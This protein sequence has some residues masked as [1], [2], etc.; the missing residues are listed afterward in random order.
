V[1]S[2]PEHLRAYLEIAAIWNESKALETPGPLCFDDELANVVELASVTCGSAATATQASGSHRRPFASVAAAAL[3]AVIFGLGAIIWYQL[4]RAP[5]YATEFGEQRSLRLADGSTVELNSRSQIRVRFTERERM[6]E[7]LY[8][9]ALFQVSKDVAR[10][11]VVSSR[12][13]RVRAVG[14]RF[15]VNLRSSGAIVTVLEGRVAVTD[16]ASN[17]SAA[18]GAGEQVILRPRTAPRPVNANVSAVTAWTQRQL[19]FESERLSDVAETF[20]RYSA[21]PLVVEDQGRAELRLSGVFST[22]PDFLIRYLKQRPDITVRET[23][24]EIHITRH[25]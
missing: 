13:A 21:R 4:A 2:S 15:D 6:I 16:R 12:S 24:T 18:V 20:N 22:D 19:V 11:F 10:P 23:H 17:V 8:G 5:S 14:T 25:E 7:L 9:Q 3:V 1:R